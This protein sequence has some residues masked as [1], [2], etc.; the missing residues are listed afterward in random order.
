MWE[1][2]W[3]SFTGSAWIARVSRLRLGLLR[4]VLLSSLALLALLSCD[5]DSASRSGV[6]LRVDVEAGTPLA[7]LTNLGS[8]PIG[9]GYPYEVEVMNGSGEWEPYRISC[10]WILPMLSLRPGG[11]YRQEITACGGQGR[12]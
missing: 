12:P 11:D 2:R 4:R 6:R 1:L 10:M 3:Y 8:E 7:T 9:Y 5:P